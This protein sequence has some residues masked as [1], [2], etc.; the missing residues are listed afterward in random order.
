MRMGISWNGTKMPKRKIRWWE[1]YKP[2]IWEDGISINEGGDSDWLAFTFT[3]MW[4]SLKHIYLS[5]CVM[6][7]WGRVHVTHDTMVKTTISIEVEEFS[8]GPPVEKT[9][10]E[11]DFDEVL[12]TLELR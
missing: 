6:G 9:A 5:V 4:G 3:V 1:S 12:K 7:V 10:I 2:V 8:F 11:K